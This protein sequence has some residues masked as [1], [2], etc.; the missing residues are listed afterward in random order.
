MIFQQLVT[1]FLTEVLV[2]ILAIA[3]MAQCRLGSFASRFGFITII[4]VVASLMTN[5][6]YWNWYS[7]PGVYTLGYITTQF[8]GFLVAGLIGAALVRQ[9][10]QVMRMAA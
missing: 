5:V 7:F 9:S 6:Q 1:E 2:S 4:G 8:V 3:L 10:P